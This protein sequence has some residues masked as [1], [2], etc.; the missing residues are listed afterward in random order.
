MIPYYS[1][2]EYLLDKDPTICLFALCCLEAL[3]NL[4]GD[5]RK[6]KLRDVKAEDEQA[7][8]VAGIL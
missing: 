8:P 4:A 5:K 3:Q 2:L 7:P 1:I 6:A